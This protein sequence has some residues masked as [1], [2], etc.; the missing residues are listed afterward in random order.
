MQER[1][2]SKDE[3][4]HIERGN[5]FEKPLNRDFFESVTVMNNTVA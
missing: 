2:L 3:K 1:E 5:L 4:P